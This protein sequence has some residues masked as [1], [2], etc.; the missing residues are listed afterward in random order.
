MRA[1]VSNTDSLIPDNAPADV[2]AV[3]EDFVEHVLEVLGNSVEGIVLFGSLV[4]G[5]FDPE[6]SDIDLIVAVSADIEEGA[7]ASLRRMHDQ[8]SRAHPAWEDRIDVAYISTAALKA[9][10][11]RDSPLLV[12]SRGEPLHR[13]RTDRRSSA[14]SASRRCGTSLPY[15]LG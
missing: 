9:V 11:D 10:T 8:L 4:A 5:G 1:A 15:R 3:L 14:C 12:I 2:R 6:T 13:A 7:L